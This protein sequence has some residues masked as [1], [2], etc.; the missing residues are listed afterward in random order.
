MR[1]SWWY[2]LRAF[3]AYR[4][5]RMPRFLVADN[6]FHNA[7]IQIHS[8]PPGLTT[9]GDPYVN[10]DIRGCVI[11][12]RVPEGSSLEPLIRVSGEHVSIQGAYIRRL[13][14]NELQRACIHLVKQP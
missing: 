13:E 11:D 5:L 6:V 10:V 14:P 3:L 2:R 1:R 9:H 8:G 4:V 7:G 12:Q